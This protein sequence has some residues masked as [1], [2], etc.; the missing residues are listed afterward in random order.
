MFKNLKVM[1]NKIPGLVLLSTLLILVSS[2]SVIEGIF[3][4]GTG[5]VVFFVILLLTF[6]AF[7]LRKIIKKYKIQS[8]Q[9]GNLNL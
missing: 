2:C 9:N 1:R 8:L 3:K 5:I 7:V 6:V 4:A